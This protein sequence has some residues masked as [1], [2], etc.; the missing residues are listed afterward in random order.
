MFW[1]ADFHNYESYFA[2]NYQPLKGI[3]RSH[4]FVAKVKLGGFMPSWRHG[5]SVHTS[6][7]RTKILYRWD[8]SV[9]VL[10]GQQVEPV[11]EVNFIIEVPNIGKITIIIP[12]LEPEAS[13][14]ISA[15]YT[16]ATTV[17]KGWKIPSAAQFHS[18]QID[19]ESAP[20]NSHF[21]EELEHI[22]VGCNIP[23]KKWLPE[24]VNSSNSNQIAPVHCCHHLLDLNRYTTLVAIRVRWTHGS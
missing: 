2:N 17:Q 14:C 23:K 5:Y 21:T 6:L 18:C 8:Q 9:I 19:A 11:P 15:Y 12:Q 3:T 1:A 20:E 24:L 22:F 4:H 13:L 7:F 10:I 16:S